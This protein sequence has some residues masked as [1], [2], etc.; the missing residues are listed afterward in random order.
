MKGLALALLA[1][2]STAPAAGGPDAR[3][4]R[5]FKQASGPCDPGTSYG[6]FCVY[7]EGRCA[8]VR[9]IPCSGVPQPPGE[10]RWKCETRR[11]DGCPDAQPA[12]GA[13][14]S[15]PGKKCSFGDCGSTELTC[16]PKT[17]RWF[18]SGGTAPPPSVPHGP[19]PHPGPAPK[20]EPGPAPAEKKA[21][22]WKHCPRAQHF[23]CEPRSQGVAPAP[24]ETIP[25]VCGCLPTCPSF[26]SV[27]ISQEIEG[28]WPDGT[29]KGTFTCARDGLP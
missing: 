12:Q 6:E 20:P 3:C 14:C 21:E 7:P 25:E 23:G 24:G 5:T 11:T 15:K 27:L 28:H 4:P 1:L 2:A 16:D 9:S 26:R 19:L 18:I 17:K 29:R 13:A 10:P 8:C 22:E